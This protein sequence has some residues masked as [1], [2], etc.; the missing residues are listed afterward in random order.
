MKFSPLYKIVS[1]ISQFCLTQCLHKTDV[2]S[3]G[4]FPPVPPSDE[5]EMLYLHLKHASLS[6]CGEIQPVTKRDYRSSF[7]RRCKNDI[8]NDK[9]HL[10]RALNSTLKVGQVYRRLFICVVLKGAWSS[11]T[12]AGGNEWCCAR[13]AALGINESPLMRVGTSSTK[14][15][16]E[17]I[18]TPS[19]KICRVDLI[20][21]YL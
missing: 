21:Y 12:Q 7:I 8:I 6:P 1:C 17:S 20:N 18:V 11:R 14:D 15:F 16:S 3:Q 10:V 19:I 2:I 9:L 13:C 5:L 4:V